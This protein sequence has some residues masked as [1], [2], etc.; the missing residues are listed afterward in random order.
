MTLKELL[1][2]INETHVAIYEKKTVAYRFV[3]IMNPKKDK[4]CISD[5]LLERE[6]DSISHTC[7]RAFQIIL[8]KE[9]DDE[10]EENDKRNTR[11][12]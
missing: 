7:N 12:N 8:C 10:V 1:P 3:V 11:I 6:I 4:G 9:K 2:L 5:E